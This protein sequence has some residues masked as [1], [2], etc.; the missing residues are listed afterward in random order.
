MTILKE[1]QQ[2]ETESNLAF[3]TVAIVL[4]VMSILIALIA[5]IIYLLIQRRSHHHQP[6]N[7]ASMEDDEECLLS[8]FG[9]DSIPRKSIRLLKTIQE[10]KLGVIYH[11]ELVGTKGKNRACLIKG[12]K[13][14]GYQA[15]SD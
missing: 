12:G 2:L 7:L 6:E 11:A 15:P 8:R 14:W 10:G 5:V 1:C 4:S 13:S 3:C 9:D